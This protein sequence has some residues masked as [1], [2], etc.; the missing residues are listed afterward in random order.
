MLVLSR[1][2]GEEF[3]IGE[4]IRVRVVAV[5][6]NQVRLGLVAPREVVIQRQEL[7]TE[8]VRCA[9]E[10]LPVPDAVL[11]HLPARSR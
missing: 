6:G 9:A 4:N 8:P 5:H 7:L 3:V 1:K 10:Q 2:I 11:H